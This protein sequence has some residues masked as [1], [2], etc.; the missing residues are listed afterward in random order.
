MRAY[1]AVADEIFVTATCGRHKYVPWGVEGGAD[2]SRNEVRFLHADGREVV[3]GK[4]ARYR[5][6][7]G[8]V[9]Q[10]VTGTGGGFGDPL[11]RPVDAVVDDVRDGYITVE[12]AEHDYGVLLD[13]ATLDVLRLSG[14]GR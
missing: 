1:R 12:Q 3:R 8:E 5:L 4:S 9:V 6:A 10:I 11:E 7:K 2:G 13:P 14:R